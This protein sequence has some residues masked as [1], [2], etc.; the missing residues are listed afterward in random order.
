MQH[1]PGL[2][3]FLWLDGTPWYGYP[4]FFIR[5]AVDGHLDCLHLQAVRNSAAM[6]NC[7]QVL[8]EHILPVFELKVGHMAY[9]AFLSDFILYESHALQWEIHPHHCIVVTR[10]FTWLSSMPLHEYVAIYLIYRWR[11]QLEVI[12]KNTTL[13]VL[14][15]VFQ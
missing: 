14:V 11:V 12:R 3:S 8:L 10:S 4:T 5:S 15:H 6:S 9:T 2:H 13:N 1:A 7:V